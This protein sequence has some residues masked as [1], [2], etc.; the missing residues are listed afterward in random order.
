[1]RHRFVRRGEPAFLQLAFL[2]EDR[3]RAGIPYRVRAGGREYYGTTDPEGQLQCPIPGNASTAT[4]WL[5]E[6]EEQEEFEIDLGCIDPITE[7]SGVLA[8]LPT[9]ASNVIPARNLPRLKAATHSRHSR[10]TMA[11][12]R[13]EMRMKPLDGSCRSA[14]MGDFDKNA[15]S[16]RKAASDAQRWQK[17]TDEKD[18][19]QYP[20]RGAQ[21]ILYV[22]ETRTWQSLPV[23]VR[24]TPWLNCGRFSHSS[25]RPIKRGVHRQTRFTTAPPDRPTNRRGGLPERFHFSESTISLIN[26]N[27]ERHVDDGTNRQSGHAERW[28]D[29]QVGPGRVRLPRSPHTASYQ[30]TVGSAAMLSRCS[31]SAAALTLCR[32]CAEQ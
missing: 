14:T 9:W 22:L 8:R 6:G 17:E 28:L 32:S 1:M 4:L 30:Q 11:C 29:Q 26:S 3:P 21:E 7:P 16:G 12:P 24:R 10:N 19:A 18:D 2:D 5:G 27:P 15:R 23:K 31:R 25:A 13:P 20:P